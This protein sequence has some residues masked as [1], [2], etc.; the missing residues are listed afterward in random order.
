MEDL[1]WHHT[2]PSL[3]TGSLSS[4]CGRELNTA[5]SASG[6]PSDELLLRRRAVNPAWPPASKVQQQQTRRVCLSSSRSCFSGVFIMVEHSRRRR[7]QKSFIWFIRNKAASF[8]AGVLLSDHLIISFMRC[9]TLSSRC[10]H[11]TKRLFQDFH[12]DLICSNTKRRIARN[13]RTLHELRRFKQFRVLNY[14]C[15]APKSEEE[16]LNG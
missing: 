16:S 10:K 2:E 15:C 4:D 3:F 5:C 11:A 14:W 9:S 7:K 1:W 8:E 13:Q 12:Q 6:S